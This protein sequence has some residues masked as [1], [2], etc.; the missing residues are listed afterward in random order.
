MISALK[1]EF[2]KLLTVRS[3]YVIAGIALALVAFVSLYIE[4]YQNGPLNTTGPGAHVF[5][6]YS[7]VQ[8][9]NILAIFSALVA[10]LLLTHEYRYNT[11]MYS[12][13]IINRRSK[14]LASKIIAVVVYTFVLALIGAVLG[15]VCM[16]I[17]LHLS[18]HAL[19]AQTIDYFDYFRRLLFFCEGYT[20]AALFL[21]AVL[22]NQVAA[23]AVFF[24][25][26]STVE[27]LISLLLKDKT[28][29]LPF[30]ALGQVIQPPAL[31]GL[32]REISS[33][34]SLTPGQGTLVF[35]AYLVAAWII[36]WV[37]FL[38]RDAN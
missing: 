2:R 21:A 30:T 23:I 6:A 13:T 12:L 7:I 36:A 15:F 24:I 32:T 26:P 16:V 28:V 4:G 9:A 1:S 17:G 25:V 5:L 33:R 38:R 10:L 20:L 19:P 8:H 22:R 37:L 35:L 29:Y 11:I 34:G 27:S 14:V 3:S 18:G 31:S